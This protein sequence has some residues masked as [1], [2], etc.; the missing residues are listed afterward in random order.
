[1]CVYIVCTCIFLDLIAVFKSDGLLNATSSSNDKTVDI[2]TN[3]D[4]LN[5]CTQLSG[6]GMLLNISFVV[7]TGREQKLTFHSHNFAMSL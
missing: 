3:Q 7:H 6:N 5:R 2:K 1:M 4:F